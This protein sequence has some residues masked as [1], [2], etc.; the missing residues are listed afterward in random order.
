MAGTKGV[1]RIFLFNWTGTDQNN[2][3]NDKAIQ[4]VGDAL[5]TL[6]KSVIANPSCKFTTVEW[7]D[8]WCCRPEPWELLVY[9][10]ASHGYS[11]IEKHN[12]T[13]S[14]T[15]SGATV[16]IDS[17]VLSEVYVGA[18]LPDPNFATLVAKCAFH[19][20]MHNKLNALP[21]FV[22]PDSGRGDGLHNNGGGGLAT[23]GQIST[24]TPL[25]AQNIS[26]MA[27]N[28]ERK[29]PQYTDE[30]RVNRMLINGMPYEFE[31]VDKTKKPTDP[32][33]FLG[34]DYN[35]YPLTGFRNLIPAPD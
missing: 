29:V 7:Q 31:L 21:P 25:T 32:G 11:L 3:W 13:V 27:A 9:L 6:F 1:F 8:G 35:S 2:R 15:A 4:S 17:K 12:I 18:M 14:K 33:Y 28:L 34:P 10:L 23:G 30:T 16:A 24:S 22:L 20:L 5:V 26:L 19:E